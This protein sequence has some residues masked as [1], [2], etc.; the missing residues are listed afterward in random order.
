MHGSQAP[1]PLAPCRNKSG[2]PEPPR[3]SLMVQPRT[4]IFVVV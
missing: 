1:A 3:I 4:A 2:G